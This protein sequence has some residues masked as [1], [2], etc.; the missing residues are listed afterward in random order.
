MYD[1]SLPR[2]SRRRRAALD[3]SLPDALKSWIELI[4]SLKTPSF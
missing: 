1:L 2:I 3:K 4:R